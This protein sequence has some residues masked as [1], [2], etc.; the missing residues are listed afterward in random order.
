[1]VDKKKKGRMEGKIPSHAYIYNEDFSDWRRIK[2]YP[3][4]RLLWNR[5][6]KTIGR[7]GDL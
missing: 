7:T 1:M 4:T 3:S 2:N 5:N 6:E